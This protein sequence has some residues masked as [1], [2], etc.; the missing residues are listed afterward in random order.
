MSNAPICICGKQM[1]LHG[2][3]TGSFYGCVDYPRC[4]HTEDASEEN[5]D[6]TED[7]F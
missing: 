6:F 1:V 5:D 3:K 4:Q 7:D 2:W